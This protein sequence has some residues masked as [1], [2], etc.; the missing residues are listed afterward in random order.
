MATEPIKQSSIDWTEF[1]NTLNAAKRVTLVG[2]I[3]PD[4][5]TL[6]SCLAL[7]RALETLGKQVLIVNGSG[8]PSTLSFIDPNNEIVKTSEMSA[9]Q[10]A[11]AASS[12]VTA[13]IDVSAWAQLGPDSSE[14][15]KTAAGGV[16]VVIDHH[17]VG[18]T[19]GDVRCVDGD[20][21]SAGSLVFEAIQALG[22]EFTEAIAS[23]LYVAISSDTGWFRFQSTSAGTLRR[24]AALLDAGVKVDEIYRL[25]NEQDSFGRYK[26][27]GSVASNCE[28]FL[29][30]RGIF[31]RLSHQDF[32]DAGAEA[33]DSEDLVN[34]PLSVAG[35]EVAV[36]AIE[37]PDGSVK[38]SFRSRCDLDCGL[39]AR[40]FGGGGHAR[41][42]GATLKQP[43]AEACEALKAKAEEYY[44]ALK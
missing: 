18:D 29:G 7:K 9:E 36:I 20:A 42:A 32:V 35:T 40:E 27:L 30:E 34:T 10:R 5:D 31:M 11:F 16:K 28:R 2:H 1:C 6:G 15:F 39:L 37:Q 41:A 25:T 13:S 19:I 22:V 44:N 12:D 43:L 21:D 38:A 23:P 17:A 8:V 14:L 33:P 4:G 3:R 26:L 24:A